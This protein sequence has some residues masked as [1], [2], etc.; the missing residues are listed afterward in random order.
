MSPSRQLTTSPL[1]PITKRHRFLLHSHSVLDGDNGSCLKHECRQHRAKLVN[2]RWLITLQQ[3][4]TAPVAHS[5]DEQLDLEV[6]GRLPL[7]EYLQNPLLRV[8]V[9]HRRTL[10]AFGPGE[11]VFHGM[12]L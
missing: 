8:L 5:N 3:H 1:Q 2:S 7:S 12:P 9:F 6:G 11:H 10:W 4:V